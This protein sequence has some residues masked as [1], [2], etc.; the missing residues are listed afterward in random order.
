MYVEGGQT[1]IL[2]SGLL[3]SLLTLA[4]CVKDVTCPTG[5]VDAKELF[6]NASKGKSTEQKR[7]DNGL[8]KKKNPKKKT[9]KRK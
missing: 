4:S 2:V 7:T 5:H 9:A 3:I 6:N 1:K 8:I